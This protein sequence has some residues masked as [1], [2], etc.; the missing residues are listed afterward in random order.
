MWLLCYS[1]CIRRKTKIEDNERKHHPIFRSTSQ[2]LNG[3]NLHKKIRLSV[4]SFLMILL[5]FIPAFHL[6]PEI[7]SGKL[8][9]QR[10]VCKLPY[11][12]AYILQHTAST[13]VIPRSTTCMHVATELNAT[14]IKVWRYCKL[15]FVQMD[16]ILGSPLNF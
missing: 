16:L 13:E 1:I 15:V 5:R 2:R 8:R 9:P 6:T 12:P 14:S 4:R 11:T 7:A 10:A 3:R